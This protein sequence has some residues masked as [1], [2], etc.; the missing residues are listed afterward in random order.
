MTGDW[1][2]ILIFYRPEMVLTHDERDALGPLDRALATSSSAT[3]I[4]DGIYQCVQTEMHA[5]LHN[6]DPVVKTRAA[7]A[8]CKAYQILCRAGYKEFLELHHQLLVGFRRIAMM[9]RKL[10]RRKML[11]PSTSDEEAEEIA[12][13]LVDIMSPYGGVERCWPSRN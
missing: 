12:Q 8:L 1:P 4:L 9:Q 2:G 11:S 13:F 10:L 6:P 7:C 3:D 5:D